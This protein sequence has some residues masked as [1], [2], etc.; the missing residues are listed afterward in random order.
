MKQ[1]VIPQPRLILVEMI[2]QSFMGM[3]K[4]WYK[5]ASKQRLN[6][7]IRSCPLDPNLAAAKWLRDRRML[8]IKMA[9]QIA[10]ENGDAELL[11]LTSIDG[12]TIRTCLE[13]R[14]LDVLEHDFI[15]KDL[16]YFVMRYI[17]SYG[18][19]ATVRAV[20][21]RYKYSNF[22]L[23]RPAIMTN[24]TEVIVYLATEG[25]VGLDFIGKEM[26]GASPELQDWWRRWKIWYRNSQ[27]R[28][29]KYL[30][31]VKKSDCPVLDP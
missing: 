13:Y 22:D 2:S 30:K 14:H 27:K 17:A 19:A 8:D 1:M 29:K 9:R 18:T 24:N 28:L 25:A 3:F 5:G 6:I 23:V 26:S 31:N 16:D 15:L 11:A 12:Q 21:A 7:Q 10:I 20:I 4:H